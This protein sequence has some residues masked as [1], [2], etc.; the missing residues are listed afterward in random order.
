[1]LPFTE[2][3]VPVQERDPEI[4]IEHLRT[5]PLRVDANVLELRLIHRVGP[6]Y[7]EQA[8]REGIAV[9]I[10]TGN[11]KRRAYS[12]YSHDDDY[13]RSKSAIESLPEF[14]RG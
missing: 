12:L 11:I 1:V 7:P 8:K 2:T 10:S 13:I 3:L 9:G 14:V 4:R 6:K 5:G